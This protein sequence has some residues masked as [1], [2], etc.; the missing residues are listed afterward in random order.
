MEDT[1]ITLQKYVLTTILLMKI[2][3]VGI[4][5]VEQERTT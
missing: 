5:K 1:L 2:F 3:G 4:T